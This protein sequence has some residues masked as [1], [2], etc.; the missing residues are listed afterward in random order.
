MSRWSISLNYSFSPCYALVPKSQLQQKAVT[1][2]SKW[3]SWKF[4]SVLLWEG[5][6]IGVVF[7]K[8][9]TQ[10]PLLVH[11]Q[12]EEKGLLSLEQIVKRN[13]WCE[14]E[15][16]KSVSLHRLF[17][18]LQLTEGEGQI[19]QRTQAQPCRMGSFE[20]K[21]NIDRRGSVTQVLHVTK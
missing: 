6:S 12:A 4:F 7:R 2:A 16:H 3:S 21:I 20:S 17:H 19:S 1:L 9:F 10:R 11:P 13:R 14:R 5:L 18:C 8:H 15:S